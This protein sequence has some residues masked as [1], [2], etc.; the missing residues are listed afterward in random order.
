MS[1]EGAQG[2]LLTREELDALLVEARAGAAGADSSARLAEPF[3]RS[4][5]PADEPPPKAPRLRQVLE[6]VGIGWGKRLASRHQ[7][8]IA[9]SLMAW[10]EVETRA[11]VETLPPGDRLVGFEA[12]PSAASGFVLVARP[13]A[14]SLLSLEFGGRRP[15][16]HPLPT[17]DYTRIERRFLRRVATEFLAG[18][19]PRWRAW[20]PLELRVGG[21]HA[22]AEVPA[23]SPGTLLLASFDVTGLGPVGRLRIGL[24]E[25]PL[26]LAAPS[27]SETRAPAREIERSLRDLELTLRVELGST[28]LS[29]AE[30]GALQ[31]GDLIEI[32]RAV[33]DGFLVHIEGR[34]KFRAVKGTVGE[35]LAV[36]VQERLEARGS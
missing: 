19:E 23:R 21:V 32:R 27:A 17:R 8:R 2:E 9:C 5:E 33:P 3:R 22:P 15:S 28:E 30:L 11:F 6:E 24:P 20:S 12:Q 13:L 34:P 14:F 26:R 25:A 10:E 36:Q 31:P 35:R 18:I 1:R 16:G 29:L 4:A 7:R